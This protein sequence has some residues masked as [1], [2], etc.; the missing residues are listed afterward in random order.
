M[1]TELG[2]CLGSVWQEHF[3]LRIGRL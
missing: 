1:A 3:A 2:A